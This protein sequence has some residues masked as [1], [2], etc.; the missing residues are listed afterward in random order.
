MTEPTAQMNHQVLFSSSPQVVQSNWD[1]AGGLE[2]QR[3]KWTVE[4][5]HTAG[6]DHLTVPPPPALGPGNYTAPPCPPTCHPPA[7]TA[8][9]DLMAQLNRDDTLSGQENHAKH[10]LALH[11]NT[12]PRR[13]ETGKWLLGHDRL[14]QPYADNQERGGICGMLMCFH[15]PGRS[16]EQEVSYED[17]GVSFG[18]RRQTSGTAGDSRGPDDY[19]SQADGPV[20]SLST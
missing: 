8:P 12:E 7:P 15:V 9:L 14:V 19:L 17:A 1:T 6:L 2:N 10:Q 4:S 20:P 16:D 11:C 3:S 18:I 5:H 13:R